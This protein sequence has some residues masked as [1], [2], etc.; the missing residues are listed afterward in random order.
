MIV[1]VIYRL[2]GTHKEGIRAEEIGRVRADQ[3]GMYAD[4]AVKKLLPKAYNLRSMDRLVDQTD[5]V[6]YVAHLYE[7]LAGDY[8]WASEPEQE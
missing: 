6:A 8:V 1:T 2:A 3:Q 4:D 7:G 5:P